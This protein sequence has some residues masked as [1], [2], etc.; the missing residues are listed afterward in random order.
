MHELSIAQSIVSCVLREVEQRQLPPVQKVVVRVGP[1]SGVFPEALR[2][3][4]ESLVV[5][6]PLVNTQLEIQEIPLRGKCKSC[7][8]EFSIEN[9]LFACSQCSATQIEVV[10]GSDLDIAYLEVADERKIDAR[11]NL[12]R[13]K[14]SIRE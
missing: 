13:E 10:S 7:G 3:G 1:L 6:T 12:D 5:N 4:F 11:E 8:C 9:N 14:G 2:F